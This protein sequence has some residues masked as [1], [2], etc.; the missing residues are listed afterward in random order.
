MYW[1]KFLSQIHKPGM[2]ENNL[3]VTYAASVYLHENCEEGSMEHKDLKTEV[4]MPLSY[5]TLTFS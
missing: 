2:E 5:R 4:A 1:L 3:S